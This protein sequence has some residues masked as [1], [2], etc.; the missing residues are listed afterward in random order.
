MTL[1]T[2]LRD[3]S[4][5]GEFG[6]AAIRR[7]MEKLGEEQIPALRTIGYILERAGARRLPS[8]S[9]P[10]A[11]TAGVVLAGCGRKTC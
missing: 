4:P 3:E 10:S 11:A 7:E 8:A 1:R 6:A 9:T 5:L 2:Q